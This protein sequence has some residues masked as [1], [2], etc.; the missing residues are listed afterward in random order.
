LDCPEEGENKM[1]ETFDKGNELV[2][3]W[4]N[5]LRGQETTLTPGFSQWERILKMREDI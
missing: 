2:F 5:C 3:Y 1:S 4:W